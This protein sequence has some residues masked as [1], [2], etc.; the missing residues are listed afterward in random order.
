LELE[1]E[2]FSIFLLCWK[3]ILRDHLELGW[4]EILLSLSVAF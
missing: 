1:L 3:K 2:G 4:P